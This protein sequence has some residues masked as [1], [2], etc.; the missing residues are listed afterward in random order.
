MTTTKANTTTTK[1]NTTTTTPIPTPSPTPNPTQHPDSNESKPLILSYYLLK[2]CKLWVWDFDDTL[3]DTKY[4]YKSNMEP[5]AILNRTDAELTKEVPQWRYFKRLVNYLV[6]HGK[7]IGIAS[8]GTYEIIK[9]YMNRILGFNQTFFNSRNIIAP[10]YQD[11]VCRRFQVP[12][13]KN[14]YIYKMMKQYKI[15][16]FKNVVLFDDLPSNIADAISVGIIGIQMATPSNG[17]KLK[18]TDGGDTYGSGGV[19]YS[20]GSSNGNG[21]SNIFFGPWVM[22][23][24]DKKIENDCGK[25]LYLNRTYTGITNRFYQEKR[26]KM[27]SVGSNDSNDT[28]YKGLSYDKT[29]FRN[30]VHESFLV[31]AAFGTGIG[32]RKITMRPDVRWNNMNVK[33]PP[34]WV[35]GNW[36]EATLGGTS[37][38]YWDKHQKVMKSSGEDMDN[39]DKYVYNN[40]KPIGINPYNK[41]LNE[42]SNYV[43]GVTEGFTNSNDTAFQNNDSD[44]EQ[45]LE[46]PARKTAFE[47][48]DD[49]YD[50][51]SKFGLIKKNGNDNGNDSNSNE[52][53]GTCKKIEWNWIILVLIIIILMM[54][55]I[56]YNS[57]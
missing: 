12:P 44:D 24:F 42:E 28:P 15:E 41:K 17:D 6:K 33:N 40:I 45:D 7:Y 43:M 20:G 2:H 23:D 25:E 55:I 36:E 8:F 19:S 50:I 48:N 57:V 9:A 22:I 49:E 13:N 39:D 14:E 35:N 54:I 46:N 16:D 47:N 5:E 30:G 18:N 52:N 29:N 37:S 38:S 4:Y 3:I 27:E 26:E 21:D 56:I 53:C 34:Q 31:P 51:K 1:A 11:R 10:M 32:N